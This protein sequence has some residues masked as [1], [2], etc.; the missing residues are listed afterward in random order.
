MTPSVQGAQDYRGIWRA[1]Q[2]VESD[3]HNRTRVGRGPALNR[4]PPRAGKE[5]PPL[6]SKGG[7]GPPVTESLENP[8]IYELM[9]KL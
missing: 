7:G 2:G 9:G 4:E 6:S 8:G 1:D 3:T 5:E